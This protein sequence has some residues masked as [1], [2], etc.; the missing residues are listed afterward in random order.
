MSNNY[1]E[2]LPNDLKREI[3]YA[4]DTY[5]ESKF[6]ETFKALRQFNYYNELIDEHLIKVINGWINPYHSYKLNELILYEY[7]AYAEWK[8][9][10]YKIYLDGCYEKKI[11]N[12][13]YQNY[14]KK[15]I[16]LLKSKGV[17]INNAKII[18]FDVFISELYCKQTSLTSI[19]YL[20]EKYYYV[21][22]DIDLNYK[23]KSICKIIYRENWKDL[24]SQLNENI[25]DK[26]LKCGGYIL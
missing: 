6:E 16:N 11:N 21:Y 22:T 7:E 3:I 23:R 19:I 25:K 15:S 20:N 14:L 8:F 5:K 9:L 1:L 13:F 24:H 10:N 26:L 4:L 17:N 12:N 18:L 2:Q